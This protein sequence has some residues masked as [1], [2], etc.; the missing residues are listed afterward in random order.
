M[1]CKHPPHRLYTWHAYDGT[2]CIGCC[3]CGVALKGAERGNETMPS[4]RI[5]PS[6]AQTLHAL[7]VFASTDET[8]PELCCMAIERILDEKIPEG[9]STPE[10]RFSICCT[11]GHVLGASLAIGESCQDFA[12]G[13]VHLLPLT[14]TSRGKPGT[15][16]MI[17]AATKEQYL[18]LD[19]SWEM[20][21]PPDK[22]EPFEERCTISHNDLALKA[23][24]TQ[25]TF[26]DWRRI[27]PTVQPHLQEG[28][29]SLGVGYGAAFAEYARRMYSCSGNQ[30]SLV[31]RFAG[32]TDGVTV[33][34]PNDPNF[35]GVWMP[36]RLDTEKA[37]LPAWLSQPKVT[38]GK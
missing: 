33:L 3:E 18:P 19:L 9:K 12:V 31:F 32:P 13:D 15:L 17:S 27:I 4:A 2:L 29:I 38:T 23:E 1:S 34:N 16:T 14:K 10:A 6:S 26:P 24:P 5:Y 30:G 7:S 28:L 11:N 35:V 25:G 21:Q 22:V 8:R 36:Y 37:K 20:V